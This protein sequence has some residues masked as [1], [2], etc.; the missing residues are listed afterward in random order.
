[1]CLTSKQTT[2][3]LCISSCVI[4]FGTFSF[5]LLNFSFQLSYPSICALT[6]IR[7]MLRH[8]DSIKNTEVCNLC[9]PYR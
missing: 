3:Q 8:P 4:V 2:G 7:E 1:M 9:K 6:V 5:L